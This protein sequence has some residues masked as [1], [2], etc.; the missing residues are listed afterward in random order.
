LFGVFYDVLEKLTSD[1][2][3]ILGAVL[4]GLLLTG[5]FPKIGL[6]WL[7]WFALA[8]LLYA[9][10]ELSPKDSFRIGFIAGLV[11]FLTL[12]Y[13]LMP[14]M[15][16][17]GYLPWYLAIS[18]LFL[19]A[20]VLALF[21]GVFSLILTSFGEKPIRGLAIIPPVWVALEYIRSFIF[22]GFPWELLGYSLFDRLHLIQIS[23]IFGV[24]GVSFLIAFSNASIFFTLLYFTKRRWQ[25]SQ[26]SIR[27]VTSSLIAL[28]I[29]IGLTWAYGFWRL[30]SIDQL[31]AASP[32]A[33]I[34][35]VQGNIEQAAKWDSAFKA[36]TVEIYNR[37]SLSAKTENP[38]LVIWPESATPFY[39]LYEIKPSEMVM[40]GIRRVDTDFL[41][42]SPSFFRKNNIV[43][44]YVS[45]YMVSP[46]NKLISR[47]DKVH[48]VPYGEY[49]PFKKWF[50]FLG[51]IVAHVGDFLPG[52]KGKTIP[53][54]DDSLGVQI[55]YEIIFPD[56]SRAMVKNNAT[57]LINITNDAWFGKT[58]GPYQHFSMTV[59]RAVENRRA[60]A[61]SANTGI[62]GFID[63]AG[64]ILASTP[65]MEE[66]VVTRSLPLLNKKT[67]YTRFGDW[68]AQVCL[69]GA[70]LIV[71]LEV[72]KLVLKS[73][74]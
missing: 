60:L 34:T 8:P 66:A 21:I 49:V 57:L 68:F 32:K 26:I 65:L 55:C 2:N 25:N 48:L 73:R 11:H 45:A 38:E 20:A 41:L 14:V 30:N 28:T 10:K 59:F 9:L 69:A 31:I 16:T 53:W 43:E 27:L 54:R 52:E 35:V 50:P 17:Y 1:R 39:F 37:L 22:S 62:S 58:G 24:Y 4:S 47:Y 36:A 74:R 12:L 51:K 40:E 13:W 7:A 46:Q 33:R 3:N 70:I 15:R 72:V 67:P 44:Y 23:D 56:L 63:P 64:R 61:R 19:F 18:V 5:S 6:D 29:A 42:G 71:L